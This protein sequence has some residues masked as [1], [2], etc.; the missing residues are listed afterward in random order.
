MCRYFESEIK[1]GI[2]EVFNSHLNERPEKRRTQ[3][4]QA[5][6]GAGS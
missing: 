5:K 1:F 6:V 4:A 2:F 3:S